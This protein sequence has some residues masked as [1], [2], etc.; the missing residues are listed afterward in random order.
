MCI[1][2]R[3]PANPAGTA[4]GDVAAGPRPPAGGSWTVAGLAAGA[5][6]RGLRRPASGPGR[7]PGR[8]GVGADRAARRR[9]R[10][11]RAAIGERLRVVPFLP[12]AS[13]A[14]MDL[15]L[16]LLSADAVALDLVSA[17]GPAVDVLAEVLP[18]LLPEPWCRP[19]RTA[20]LASLGVRRIVTADVVAVVAG[21]HRPAEWWRGLYAALA[22]APDREALGALPVPLADG[23][24]ATGPRG[25]VAVP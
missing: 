22:D 20:A 19:A 11:L 8:A 12:A 17:T 1:S 13:P 25:L 5:R 21:L 14:D 15:G 23:G 10:R 9:P 2:D 16:R 18:G 24:T 7:G 6:R 4:R 3:R